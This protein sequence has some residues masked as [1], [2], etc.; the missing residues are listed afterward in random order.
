M[1]KTNVDDYYSSINSSSDSKDS[2]EPKKKVVV[3]KRVIIK[4]TVEKKEIIEE[5]KI[6]K[7]ESQT[8][9]VQQNLNDRINAS[10]SKS[11]MRVIRKAGDNSMINKDKKYQ[12]KENY[13]STD[14]SNKDQEQKPK[15]IDFS[16]VVANDDKKQ[17]V[18]FKAWGWNRVDDID[19]TWGK[20]H[21]LSPY[22]NKK[23]R[24]R[25]DY[26]EED[27]TKFV[28]SN[29]L[30]KKKKKEKAVEDIKQNLVDRTWE[31]IIIP[32]VLN[33]KE[34]SEK[35]WVVLPALIA[36]FMKNGLMVNI[37]SK[38]DFETAS[39]IADSFQIKLEKDNSKWMSVEDVLT[40][41]LTK[42]LVEDDTSKLKDRSPVISIMWHV[43]HWKTSLLDYIRQEKV[44]SME[45]G[46]ITQSIW[47]YQVEKNGQT[48]TFLD[49][50][51]HEAFT[52]MRA[53]WAKSTDIAI[54]VVAAD[55][56]VK[57]QTIESINH[58]KEAWIPIIVAIN[59]MD[60][61]GA[62]PD[63]VKWQ[64]SEHWLT[65]EDWWGETPM[66]PVS[67]ITW[68]GI[69]DLLEII[70]LVS[71]MQELKANPDR[72]WVATVIESH[73]DTKF[74]PVSTVL[75][76]T[77]TVNMW[78]N[79]V[80][81]HASWKIKILK[82][83]A[84]KKIKKAWPGE[85]ILIVW[86]DAVVEWWDIMQVVSTPSLAREKA[87]EYSEIMK[88]KE[89]INASWLEVLMSKIKA[90][91]LKQL[92]IVLK[93]DTNGSLE[94]IKWAITKLST[95]ETTVTI[96]H[97]WV[98]SITEWDI[99]MCEWSE[100][101]LVWFNVNVLNTAQNIL[102]STK[103]EFINSSIIYHITEKIEKIVTGMFDP[104]EIEIWLCK[105]EVWWIFYTSKDFM[106]LWLRVRENEKIENNALVRVFRKDKFVWKW[107]VASLKQWI[108]E[109]AMLEWPTE[110]WIKFVWE[111]KVEEKDILEIYKVEI[112]K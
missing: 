2:S 77:W 29:T 51:G 16:R 32:D 76:N 93:S 26:E 59:K 66:V 13:N 49:T 109:I 83:Y 73:L 100:A 30:N 55:E 90:W 95:P 89:W 50:P 54:L 39:I 37:N 103:V 87:L 15:A 57:P 42:L 14:R 40:W 98:W 110:C 79:I 48:I 94:A 34:L 43:D 52:I 69:D 46:W 56:W 36:E 105:A 3:K 21:K 63:H 11:W 65:P 12:Q 64:L 78:D 24:G 75:V 112:Q 70:L 111:V 5:K 60:K 86:L 44:A 61:E 74:W 106:V 58:A 41:D 38:I 33:L 68:F 9:E 85:P 53:R 108:E 10:K 99:L 82:N 96:I 88:R 31:T 17:K 97:S 91:N 25:F 62:N 104:K 28:R 67:A 80:C 72:Q 35:L 27:D 20:K 1:T 19:S 45:A 47:A 102:Q 4:K 23:S 8:Q 7:K 18:K 22:S 81:T 107:K 6:E 84:W 101:I 71:E 92:K